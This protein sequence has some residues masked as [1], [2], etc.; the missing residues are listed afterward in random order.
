MVTFT[1]TPQTTPINFRWGEAVGL[2][3]PKQ[4][5]SKRQAF[6]AGKGDADE[7][8]QETSVAFAKDVGLKPTRVRSRRKFLQAWNLGDSWN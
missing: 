7:Q 6:R 3:I 1:F 8:Q 5:P 4:T 2:K